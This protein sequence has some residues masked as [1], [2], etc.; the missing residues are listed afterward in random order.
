MNQSLRGALLSGL[1]FPG[2]GQV[3][4]KQYRRGII[5]ILTV[6]ACFLVIIVRAV[7]L[8]LVIL[9][10]IDS[11]NVEIDMNAIRNLI[12]Q[13]S[14]SSDTLIFRFVPLLIFVLW[15]FAIVDSYRIGKKKDLEKQSSSQ[16]PNIKRLQ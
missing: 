9:E 3:V 16:L 7:E 5:I 10:K 4:L 6:L 15:I 11:G 13:T 8:A 12:A 2:L 1:V 14:T